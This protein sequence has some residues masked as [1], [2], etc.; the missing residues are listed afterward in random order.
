[1]TDAAIQ[2][3]QVAQ[4]PGGLLRIAY[5]DGSTSQ[6]PDSLDEAGETVPGALV[7]NVRLAFAWE[8]VLHHSGDAS[9]PVEMTEADKQ[10]YFML[11][12]EETRR[13]AGGG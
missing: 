4:V 3:L 13:A 6:L 11:R 12:I 10:A 7:L 8:E 2:I 1:V 5:T 9:N